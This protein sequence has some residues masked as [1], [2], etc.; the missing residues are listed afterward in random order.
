MRCHLV[1][2]VVPL[3]VSPVYA[4]SVVSARAGLINYSEGA[5]FADNQPVVPRSGRYASLKQGSE[6]FTEDGRAE[7]LISPGGYLR[8]G[9]SSAVRMVST[10]LSDPQVEVLSGSVV[11]D[12]GNATD[13]AAVTLTIQ[14]ARIRVEKPSR[15][16]IDAEP[17]EL[18]V[19]KGEARV[20]RGG[21]TTDVRAEQLLPLADSSIVQRMTDGSDDMLD[22]WSMQRNRLIYLNLASNQQIGDPG[23]DTASAAGD[24]AGLSWP[25]Y[26]P[27]T[28]LYSGVVQP[29]G[30][31]LY[32]PY[33][34]Y[35]GVFRYGF[36]YVPGYRFASAYPGY[37]YGGYRPIGLR[38]AI[39]GIA[40][41]PMG[42]PIGVRPM[43]P[44][45][46][47]IRPASPRPVGMRAPAHR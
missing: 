32:P 38:T 17:P 9:E 19:Y 33:S 29:Y 12:S 6:L 43:A 35:G 39:G 27:M 46:I 42:G 14:G 47:T 13:S 16:R 24:A 30:Y 36:A 25:G 26:V 44:T 21:S 4:Q 37:I 15:I 5:V 7:V 11:F 23:D 34:I 3:L 2:L 31:S 41:R 8:V 40:I 22:T 1:C 18:R 28:G 10:D 45:P 20:E